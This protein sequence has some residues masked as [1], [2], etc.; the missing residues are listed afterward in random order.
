MN[1]KNPDSRTFVYSTYVKTT[2]EKL[3]Q[4]L[5]GGDFSE[6]Y[7]FGFRVESD[8]KPGSP[9][10]IRNPKFMDGKGDS[11]GTVIACD[12]PHRV[13]Y[14]FSW[15]PDALAEQRG[16]PTRVTYELTPVGNMVKLTLT[17][18]NLLAPDLEAT[19]LTLRGIHNGWP[20]ILSALKSLIETGE[21]LN[22]DVL[23]A[24]FEP[25]AR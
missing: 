6:K 4:A 20:A 7:W 22:F 1:A 24:E 18:E 8:W 2:P 3:W 13:T 5:T 15:Q 23:L 10:Y 16:G 21:A 19:G 17:H 12:S 14:T 9:M 11:V 25:P